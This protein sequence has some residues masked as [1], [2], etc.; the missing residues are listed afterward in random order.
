MNQRGM[1][2]INERKASDEQATNDCNHMTI[3]I[4]KGNHPTMER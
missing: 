4:H 2:A 1:K 3:S